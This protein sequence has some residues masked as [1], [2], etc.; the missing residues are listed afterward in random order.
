M[1]LGTVILDYNIHFHDDRGLTIIVDFDAP[2]DTNEI[3]G[4]L[5]DTNGIIVKEL[6]KH[7]YTSKPFNFHCKCEPKNSPTPSRAVYHFF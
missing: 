4:H 1:A 5:N 3:I 6:R 7:G 2:P